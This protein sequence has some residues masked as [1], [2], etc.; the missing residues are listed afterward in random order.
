MELPLQ[1]P[2]TIFDTLAQ[3][4]TALN[5]FSDEK[6]KQKKQEIENQYAAQT[7]QSDIDYKNA[8]SD[9]TKTQNALYPQKTQSEMGYQ[10]ALTREANQKASDPLLGTSGFGGEQAALSYFANKLGKDSPEF[11]KI[12]DDYNQKKLSE[13]Q[14]SMSG[15]GTGGREEQFFQQLVSK[16]NPQLKSPDKI[17]EASNVLR[18]GGD[19]LSDGTIL[20]PLSPASKAS[21]DR[22]TKGTTTAP[23]ITKSVQANQA[24]AEIQAISGEAQK[25]IHD[26]GDTVLGY[27]P[28]QIMDSFK[29][30]KASQQKLGR[31]IAGQQVQYEIAQNEIKLANGQPGVTSTNELMNLGQQMIK[32]KYPKLSAEAREA[33]QKRFTE[34]LQ[35]GLKARN[36]VGISPSDISKGG[37]GSSSSSGVTKLI[38]NPT[39]GKLELA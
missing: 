31:F 25:D 12:Q 22:I 3:E 28:Q 26:Y 17:Y 18:M 21:F 37:G 13:Q 23:L 16:D 38:R 36:K 14:S 39:T 29:S 2:T 6:L 11:K 10:N 5:A 24:D 1:Q 34:I 8:Q 4:A 19:R 20:N 7:A 32:A 27:S 30:D 9:Y 15:L 35:I 33:A